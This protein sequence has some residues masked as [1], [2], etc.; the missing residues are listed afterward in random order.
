MK[1]IEN[2]AGKYYW[3]GIYGVGETLVL[4]NDKTFE[5]KWHQGLMNGISRGKYT[6]EKKLITLNSFKQPE[7][8]DNFK[9][10]Y[11]KTS[12]ENNSY[13]IKILGLDKTP[14]GFA[15]CMFIKNGKIIEGKAAAENGTLYFTKKPIAEKL[16]IDFIGYNKAEIEIKDLKT[17]SFEI[18]LTE[19]PEYY[20]YFTNRKFK[21]RN[22]SILSIESKKSQNKIYKR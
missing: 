21:M 13:F 5:F 2:L 20:E 19:T 1:N 15:N 17:N 22:N 18:T 10:H 14:L 9:I 16:H 6:L 12:A 8:I 11:L 7:S 4:N 3:K